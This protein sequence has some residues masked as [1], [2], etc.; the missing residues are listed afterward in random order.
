[1]RTVPRA[2]PKARAVMALSEAREK[3]R[4]ALECVTGVPGSA[5]LV[6]ELEREEQRL[7]SLTEKVR[8]LG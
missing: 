8:A 7:R 5:R 3:V 4:V 6:L 2:T 1:M